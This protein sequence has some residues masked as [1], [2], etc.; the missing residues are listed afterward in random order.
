METNT[1][2]LCDYLYRRCGGE[3]K[4]GAKKFYDLA[5][6]HQMFELD[7]SMADWWLGHFGSAL[8]DVRYD[9]REELRAQLYDFARYTCY[10][11]IVSCRYRREQAK[12]S[13]LF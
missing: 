9:I 11:L 3:T 5:E 13:T 1:K 2:N 10:M 6:K 7:E 12:H 8:L 4:L